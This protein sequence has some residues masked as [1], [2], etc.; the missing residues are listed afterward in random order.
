MITF[1]PR[2]AAA[3]GER[4]CL[5]ACALRCL[6]P[7]VSICIW[8]D[9]GEFYI[10]AAMQWVDLG[11]NGEDVYEY[12][13]DTGAM[14][15][16]YWYRAVGEEC[17]HQLSVYDPQIA[18]PA[19]YGQGVTYH[20]F[21]DRFFRGKREPLLEDPDFAIHRD[22]RE[23]PD[24]LPDENGEILNRDIYG[25]DLP[26]VIE[27]LPY[28]KSLGVTTIYL[29]PIFEAWSNHKYNT[30]DFQKIDAHFG[31]ADTLERL[32]KAA[33]ESGI[34][35]I[36]DGVFNHVGSDSVY[37]NR[38]GRYEKPGA[39]QSE[40]SEYRKWF[41][42]TDTGYDSWWGIWTLPTVN[43]MEPDYRAFI[44]QTAR[45]WMRR[46]IAGWRLDVADE[47]PDAFLREFYEVVKSER[48][49]AVIIG[50]VWEDASNKIAYS[51]RRKYFTERELDG[52]M[53]Y[54]LRDAILRFVTGQI[55]SGEARRAMNTL[56]SHYPEPILH[57]LM[58][59]IGTHDTPRILTA[60]IKPDIAQLSRNEQAAVRLSGEEKDRAKARL[61][62]AVVLQYAFPGS[63]AIYYGDEAGMEGGADPF[64]RAYFPWGSEDQELTSFYKMLG[65][66]KNQAACMQHGAFQTL[67]TEED[68]LVILR[69]DGEQKV[70]FCVGHVGCALYLPSEK[71]LYDVATGA[72][73]RAH[74]GCVA[75]YMPECGYSVLTN[76]RNLVYNKKTE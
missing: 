17:V 36:L 75:S 24:Y 66:L 9:V 54:P 27:K 7:A 15:G 45:M 72:T 21:V 34:R 51:V 37:F 18:P 19:W 25:G 1:E 20:I 29:S 23:I 70:F 60:L 58:N 50:E 49:D 4:V 71:D 35:V 62:Q 43:K 67:E 10:E 64:N 22:V 26:G 31:D 41:H 14:R 8:A 33:K 11:E 53:N 32:C 59:H 73:L 40:T 61:R 2:G 3:Q 16:L 42:F 52:V 28:L 44:A 13:L 5:R 74:F 68:V 38:A 63:P 6:H 55:S 69:C 39:W 65:W 56:C 48:A 12:T 46:G 57:T 30:A 47:L 76:D